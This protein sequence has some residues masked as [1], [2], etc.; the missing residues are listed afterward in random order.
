[1]LKCFYILEVT[2]MKKHL[3]EM[4]KSIM[5]KS[6]SCAWIALEI[7]LVVFTFVYSV[8]RQTFDLISAIPLIMA[9]MSLTGTTEPRRNSI[10]WGTAN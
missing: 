5:L 7:G 1:M 6:V 10:R 9:I 8:G 4:E 3:D 2:H